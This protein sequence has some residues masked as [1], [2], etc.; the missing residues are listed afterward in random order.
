M[1]D[2]AEATRQRSHGVDQC[3]RFFCSFG[4]VHIP[5]EAKLHD[6]VHLENV[7]SVYQ[8]NGYFAVLQSLTQ[9]PSGSQGDL[10]HMTLRP[11]PEQT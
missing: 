4:A 8:V 11:S 2:E 9:A 7:S 6:D 10:F 1:L 3:L 5:A